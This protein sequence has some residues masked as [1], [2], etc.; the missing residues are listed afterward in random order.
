MSG[1]SKI[2]SIVFWVLT[3]GTIAVLGTFYMGGDAPTS[4]PEMWEPK[5]TELLLFWGY[6]LLGLGIV[7]AVLF[8]LYHFSRE[9]KDKPSEAMKSLLGMVA[10]VVMFFVSWTM[11]SGEEL[12]IVGYDGADNIYFWLKWAD[13]L[14]Y[15]SYFL[16]TLAIVGVASSGFF[17]LFQK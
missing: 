9:L 4:T 3:L 5:Y 12:T 13:M 10:V 17:K 14:L 15:A 16:I 7:T 8:A 1:I 2:S 11:G 6:I